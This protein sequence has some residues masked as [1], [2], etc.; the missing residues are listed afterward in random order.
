MQRAQ[1]GAIVGRSDEDKGYRICV[2]E[3]K[4]DIVTQHVKNIQTLSSVQ[5]GH[6]QHILE[7]EGGK[8]DAQ[9]DVLTTRNRCDIDKKRKGKGKSK[10]CMRAPSTTAHKERK[11]C[12]L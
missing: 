8:G 10:V 4:V 9:G 5:N 3:D 11:R 12:K 6:L 1:V 2:R 7:L